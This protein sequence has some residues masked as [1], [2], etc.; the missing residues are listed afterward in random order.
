[1]T[2]KFTRKHSRTTEIGVKI[3]ANLGGDDDDRKST[4]EV[5]K[6]LCTLQFMRADGELLIGKRVHETVEETLELPPMRVDDERAMHVKHDTNDTL[7]ERARAAEK[8]RLEKGLEPAERNVGTPE[9]IIEA[10]N[11]LAAKV[12]EMRDKGMTIALETS[13]TESSEA[14]SVET[15][16]KTSNPSS[17]TND[18]EAETDVAQQNDV[19]HGKIGDGKTGLDLIKDMMGDSDVD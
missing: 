15:I 7:E 6:Y 19:I 2:G 1:M 16:A 3:T 13:E 10:R 5:L 9:E 8:R 12:Q 18:P 17:V 11:R 4:W 14:V